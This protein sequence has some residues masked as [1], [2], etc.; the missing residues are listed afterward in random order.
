MTVSITMWLAT[1]WVPAI[2]LGQTVQPS[3]AKAGQAPWTIPRTP[4]GHPDLQ[5]IWTT[6]TLTPLERPVALGDKAFLTAEEAAALATRAAE[7][8]ANEDRNRRANDPGTYNSFWLEN[9]TEV[10]PSRRTSLIIDPPTGRIPWKAEVLSENRRARDE[11]AV[12]NSWA[13]LDTGERCLTDGPTSVD[14][15]GYNMNFQILQTP[16]HV[17]ITHEMYHQFVIV[18]L[19]GR[20]R[21]SKAIG[22]WLGDARGRWE[23]N[24]L[25]VETLNFSD[26][27]SD[28]ERYKWA[29][30]GWRAARPTLRLVERYTRISEDVIAY[31]F[32][33][34][35]S[36]MFTRPW[37]AAPT[38][39]RTA[40]P[41]F[42]YACHEGN[43]AVANTLRG[44]R[45]KDNEQEQ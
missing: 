45:L 7:S 29:A 12:Y 43:H 44:A 33:V 15:Q 42:E 27:F 14:S 2:T 25:L 18:P 11:P 10:D 34:E 22:M 24:T 20:P 17:V 26:K 38:M 32:T 6:Q 37:T 4:W 19:D 41:I 13:D 21:L 39:R 3:T 35:D 5:G 31:Q 28:K 40:G 16:D 30:G 36:T 8:V 9:G 23:G 1:V